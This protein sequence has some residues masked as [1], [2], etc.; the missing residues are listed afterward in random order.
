M[1]DPIAG[2]P[3]ALLLGLFFGAGACNITCLPFLGPVLLARTDQQRWAW[4]TM[5]PFS[6]GRLGGYAL[7]GAGA[8]FL[9]ATL[10]FWLASHWPRWLLATG[11]VAT[12]LLLLLRSR[13]PSRCEVTA[14]CGS[15][16]G[17]LLPRDLMPERV[18]LFGPLFLMG[19]GMALNPLCGPLALVVLAA[20][21]SA[22]LWSGLVLGL[23]FGV[24]AVLLPFFIFAFLV[25]GI[26]AE[27]KRQLAP[28]RRLLERGA[29][30]LLLIFGVTLYY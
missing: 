20:A 4:R 21:A 17:G 22:D 10:D 14:N 3:G 23:S 8:G 12:A 6:L 15:T 24:G 9:G 13:S 30:A 5:L 18:V 2:W 28:W 16:M 19:A 29:A 26:S 1:F 7:L 27:L 11:T 25:A